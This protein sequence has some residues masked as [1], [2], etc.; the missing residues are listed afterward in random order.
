M[1]HRGADVEFRGI[2]PNFRNIGSKRVILSTGSHVGLI[3]SLHLEHPQRLRHNIL[4]HQPPFESVA[5]L[6]LCALAKASAASRVVLVSHAR[7]TSFAITATHL[8]NAARRPGLV[9]DGGPS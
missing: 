4:A 7:P 2:N 9:Q 5:M 1:L 8:L 3:G 6:N